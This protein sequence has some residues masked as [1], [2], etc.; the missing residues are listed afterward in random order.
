MHVI[1]DIVLPV[2]GLILAGFAFGRPPLFSAEAARGLTTFVFHL[3]IPA[4]LFRSMAE[5]GLPGRDDLAILEAYYAAV[6][7]VGTMAVL[8]GRYL[9]HDRLAGSAVLG[10]GATFSNTVQIGVPLALAA[11][12]EAGL[13]QHLLIVTFH[14]ALLIGGYTVLVEM[15]LAE[16]RGR[17]LAVLG[18][19]LASVARNPIVVAV[20]AGLAVGSLGIPIPGPADRLLE[21]L[22]GA[23]VPCA[24]FSLGAGLVGLRT[25]DLMGPSLMVV[26][27]KLLALPAAV[28]LLGRHVFDLTPLQLAVA[29]VCATLP[30]GANAFVFA[31]RYDIHVLPTA[32]AV[33]VTT[34]LSM[35]TTGAALVWFAAAP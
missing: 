3:A 6:L 16:G 1:L 26:V 34:A 23:A 18:T 17:P 32:S 5:A 19:T 24:L 27:L 33:L 9:L 35:V 28:W 7:I 21:M 31:Q 12:G 11:F 14:A 22:A 29:T 2:F 4:L 13:A 10:I 25:G 8:G 15:D 20:L 30:S